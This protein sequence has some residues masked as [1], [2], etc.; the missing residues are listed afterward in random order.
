MKVRTTVILVATAA[1]AFAVFAQQQGA[2]PAGQ[3][4]RGGRGAGRGAPVSPLEESGFHPIFDGTLKGWD[5][6]PD[7]WK[8]VNGV[9]TGET[10]A[11]HQPKQNEFIIWRGGQPG[12]FELKLDYKLSGAD[13]GNSGIQY[14][15]EEL[16]DVA[17]WVL[18]GYQADIDARQ[19]YTGQIYEERGRGFLALRGQFSYVGDGKK[20]GSI[21]SLGDGDELKKI[22]KQDDF[23]EIHIVAKGNFIV[24]SINGHVMSM[25]L[26]DDRVGRR[27]G[28]VLGIQLHRTPGP[29]KIEAKNIRL[30]DL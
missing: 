21:S 25:L 5:G 11:D 17:R 13:T 16:P 2:P 7:F 4:G 9:M 14:R 8:V 29:L 6:N 30:K 23:N 24:Q 22:I 19:V 10:T 3:P 1:I 26:D 27:M 28:G 18:K 15:S 20:V 12:D